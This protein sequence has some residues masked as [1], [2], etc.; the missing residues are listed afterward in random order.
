V[1]PGMFAQW[2]VGFLTYLHHTH[3]SIPWFNDI[4]EWSFYMGQVRGTTHISFPKWIDKLLFNIME[5]TA[6]HV[7]QKIPL[8]HLEHAQTAL[9]EEHDPVHFQFGYR[10]LL[11][12][13]RV[14]QLYDF[15]EHTW[16]SY[17]GKQ[18]S[19]RTVSEELLSR[20]VAA[21][22]GRRANNTPTV[23]AETSPDEYSEAIGSETAAVAN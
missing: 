5:H 12:T 16:L 13:Q 14:C 4:D 10:S 23:T 19:S 17:D 6:H 2:I 11:Y 20:V 9:E 3:P 1:I 15:T 8:Y 7:D 22:R 18:T 21:R